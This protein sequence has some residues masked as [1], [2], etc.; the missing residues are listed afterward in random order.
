[1]VQAVT[2]VEELLDRALAATVADR[3]PAPA[4]ETAALIERMDARVDDED[5]DGPIELLATLTLV[6]RL[7][8]ARDAPGD[9]VAGALGWVEA[10]LGKRCRA[11]AAFVSPL[12]VSED[13]ADDVARY[14]EALRGEFVPALLW[15]V[16]GAGQA[17]ARPAPVTTP[18]GAAG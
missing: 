16:A 12:L 1:M 14:R 17:A 3:S 5:V 2:A 18:R 4:R 8:A 6:G 9:P 11:R 13:A 10:A 7:A 15:L